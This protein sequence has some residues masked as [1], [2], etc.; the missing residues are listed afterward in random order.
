MKEE[1]DKKLVKVFP[2]LY[3]D[4]ERADAINCYVLGLSWRW[5]V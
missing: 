3:D 2:L 5:M 4:R 1:L